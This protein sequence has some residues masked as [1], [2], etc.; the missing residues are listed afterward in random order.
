ML[1]RKGVEPLVKVIPNEDYEEEE[2]IYLNVKSRTTIEMLYDKCK[3][4]LNKF[5]LK[6]KNWKFF[7][8]HEP[9]SSKSKY[10]KLMSIFQKIVIAIAISLIIVFFC[11][12]FYI[13]IDIN[14]IHD[15]K[16]YTVTK[17]IVF[18]NKN[19]DFSWN[20]PNK[21]ELFSFLRARSKTCKYV[22]NPE[23]ISL[24]EVSDKIFVTV[25]GIWNVSMINF[26]EK[27]QLNYFHLNLLQDDWQFN[28]FPN[29]PSYLITFPCICTLK[30]DD[31]YIFTVNLRKLDNE[32]HDKKVT[33]N[34]KDKYLN[35][36]DSQMILEV[37]THYTYN[38]ENFKN[39]SF[40]L[41]K[42]KDILLAELCIQYHFF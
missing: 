15:D 30:I 29:V 26:L 24:Y 14:E 3:N 11:Y 33:I 9:V 1:R 42:P 8:F 32:K 39:Q 21:Y 4:N 34:F 38:D 22:T 10:D 16:I 35:N 5:L 13:C 23:L 6:F 36:L 17:D 41:K 19:E 37:P 25:L 2:E 40:T 28:D 18:I 31:H 7:F 12:I 27:Y 20:I